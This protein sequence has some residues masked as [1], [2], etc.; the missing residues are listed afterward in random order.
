VVH[1]AGTRSIMVKEKTRAA[2]RMPVQV[3]SVRIVSNLMAMPTPAPGR[4][5]GRAAIN[6]YAEGWMKMRLNARAIALAGTIV[7]T[8]VML[9]LG[10]LGN[11]G[12]YEG[13][14]EMMIKWHVLFSL[15]PLGIVGGMIE[16]GIIT[17]V[18]LYAFAWTYN[19]LI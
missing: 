3:S 15:S 16:A 9:L 12:I 5:A 2:I 10:I 8:A 4:K 17:F 14:V 13:A 6:R 1:M 11:L 7:A 18:L 19:K